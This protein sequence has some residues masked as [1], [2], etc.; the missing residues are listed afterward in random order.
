MG[1]KE[2]SRRRC[3][4]LTVMN[5][6]GTVV[7]LERGTKSRNDSIRFQQFSGT[8]FRKVSKR[9]TRTRDST[10]NDVFGNVPESYV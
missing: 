7:Q 2:H 6:W 1:I 9:V 3:L 10:R 4:A 5:D 8:R